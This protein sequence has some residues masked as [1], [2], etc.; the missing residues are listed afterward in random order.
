MAEKIDGRST[1]LLSREW[2]KLQ[3]WRNRRYLLYPV[4]YDFRYNKTKKI[5]HNLMETFLGLRHRATLPVSS[6]KNIMVLKRR[7]CH[8]FSGAGLSLWHNY[9]YRTDEWERAKSRLW[10][11]TKHI[12]HSASTSFI[13]IYFIY[14]WYIG[15]IYCAH[16]FWCIK[17]ASCL[18]TIKFSVNMLYYTQYYISV[19]GCFFFLCIISH[20][21]HDLPRFSFFTFS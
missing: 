1:A 8:L 3:T 10:V 5:A 16:T 17:C 11:S 20:N 12:S 15:I 18:F 4:H 6:G 19:Y 9:K 14:I 21:F 2:R 13:F 7:G